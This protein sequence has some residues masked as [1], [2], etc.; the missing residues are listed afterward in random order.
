MKKSVWND[1]VNYIIISNSI[2]MYTLGCFAVKMTTGLCVSGTQK[3]L[4][5]NK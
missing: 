2:T 4:I 5:I 3:Q 1:S